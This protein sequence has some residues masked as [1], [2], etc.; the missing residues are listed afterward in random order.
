MGK[1]GLSTPM[2]PLKPILRKAR[3]VVY[4]LAYRGSGRWCPLCESHT[5]RFR[6]FGIEYKR[7]QA[8]CV[9]CG[10]LER[11]RLVWLFLT[12]RTTAFTGRQS[13]LHIAPEPCEIRIRR[14]V[15]PGYVSADLLDRS[16]DVRLDI[17]RLP[18]PD[19]AFDVVYCSHVLE[20]V[21]DDLAAMREF[22]RVLAPGG[23]ALF[24]VPITAP[25]TFED[26]TI[27]DPRDRLLAFGQ[28]DHVRRYGPDFADRLVDAGFALQIIRSEDVAEPTEISVMG[29]GDAGEIFLATHP[30]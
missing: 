23:L 16:V 18:Y 17:T 5:R 25:E 11:H 10:A 7:E 20:H 14:K 8:M 26:P 3:D 13:M 2:P 30:S 1:A 12:R 21:A 22:R 15:G 4:R 29:L 6:P 9:H 28:N 24:L 27:T 19:G